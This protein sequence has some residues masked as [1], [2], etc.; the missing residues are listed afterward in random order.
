MIEQA[1]HIPMNWRGG[2]R[3]AHGRKYPAAVAMHCPF[4]G[5]RGVF[6][7]PQQAKT[8]DRSWTIQAACPAC[9]SKPTLTVYFPVTKSSADQFDPIG[10]TVFPSSELDRAPL[11]LPE[12]FP[13]RLATA[14][15]D[16]ENALKSGLFGA[17][18]TSGG[19]A[20]EGVF[21]HLTNSDE[22]LYKMIDGFVGSEQS[23]KPLRDLAHAIRE[24]RNVGAHFDQA[25]EPDANSAALIIDLLHY[26][27]NYYF[28]LPETVED[29]ARHFKKK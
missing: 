24:G 6:S 17:A 25:I 10:L 19:R 5:E 3:I 20:L 7:L 1:K 13:A 15:S 29:V 8:T 12:G 18:V 16:A 9:N 28:I 14:I 27:V 22:T 4:C 21:M 2:K 26:I 11:C 23:S